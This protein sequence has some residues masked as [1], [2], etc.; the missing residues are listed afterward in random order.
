MRIDDTRIVLTGAACGHRRGD[1]CPARPPA[2]PSPGRR[3]RRAAASADGREPP[4]LAGPNNPTQS[5]TWAS[6]SD[7]DAVFERAL[8]VFGLNGG[9]I[10][11]FIANAGF[12]YYERLSR[13]DWRRMDA[14]L[15]V[16]VI[17][18]LYAAVKMGE[19]NAGRPHRTVVV[20]SAMGRLAIPGY[21]LYS[22]SKAALHR[23]AEAYRYELADP[24]SLTLVYPI[25]TRTRFFQ[26]NAGS[27]RHRTPGPLS[28]PNR[29]LGLSSAAS[30]ATRRT[31]TPR[32]SSGLFSSPIASCP[33]SAASNRQSKAGASAAGCTAD[34][35]S[36]GLG[37]TWSPPCGTHRTTPPG[38]PGPP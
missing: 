21:A 13:A 23:F 28:R 6:P 27:A 10:D 17:S 33:S 29:W 34:I 18:P 38:P 9:G 32:R 7:V 14:L 5:P 1:P 2:L 4:A 8:A 11:L 31:S 3:L 16:N 20:A 30:S 15:H 26:R 12:A 22:G 37:A 19:L 36:P 25:G 24:A 35:G